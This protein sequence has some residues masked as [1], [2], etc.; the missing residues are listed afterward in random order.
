MTNLGLL[1]LLLA[2]LIKSTLTKHVLCTTGFLHA[3]VNT[4]SWA[5]QS[6]SYNRSK[7]D[8]DI[9]ADLTARGRLPP[10][11]VSR[12]TDSI[13]QPSGSQRRQGGSGRQWMKTKAASHDERRK[14]AVDSPAV[15]PRHW[16]RLMQRMHRPAESGTDWS[17]TKDSSGVCRCT[18]HL[19]GLPNILGMVTQHRWQNWAASWG[20]WIW[21]CSSQECSSKHIHRLL[22]L[23]RRPIEHRCR[24]VE[25][26]EI[27]QKIELPWNEATRL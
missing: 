13:V 8:L 21:L 14:W 5:M 24:G 3:T 20:S 9:T 7:H 25:L 2:T 6:Y 26:S 16:T 22:I 4:F 23:T 27:M 18:G 17:E 12:R 10:G 11:L 1:P 15:A 19:F